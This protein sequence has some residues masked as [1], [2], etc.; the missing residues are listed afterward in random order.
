MAG[1]QQP[2]RATPFASPTLPRLP[3]ETE[4]APGLHFAGIGRRFIS[5]F[6][7]VTLLFFTI[8]VWVPAMAVAP[9]VL[10]GQTRLTLFVSLV[11]GWVAYFAL[12]WAR[13]RSVGMRVMGIHLERAKGG[14][15]PGYGRALVRALLAST[16]ALAAVV[17]F[18]LFF[19]ERPA[20]C[21]S[22]Q[23][24]GCGFSTAEL[25]LLWT[26][27]VILPIGL[28]TRLT[29]V[30]DQRFQSLADHAAGVVVLIDPPPK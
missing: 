21:Y 15:R 29:M 23:P 11:V 2:G 24:Q 4:V 12:S 14:G 19:T 9:M 10:A 7:D 18:A 1:L 6:L 27:T 22:Q 17:I 26:A 20:T 28:M 16:P 8:P 13:G 5:F 3:A 30:L 25:A